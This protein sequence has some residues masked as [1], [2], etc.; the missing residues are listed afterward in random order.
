QILK[1]SLESW[2]KTNKSFASTEGGGFDISVVADTFKQFQLGASRYGDDLDNIKSYALGDK[3]IKSND[4]VLFVTAR[5]NQPLFNFCVPISA[6]NAVDKII[7]ALTTRA[8]QQSVLALSNATD[9]PLNNAIEVKVLRAETEEDTK[10]VKK[11]EVKE[12]DQH[13]R[14]V[15]KSGER[16]MFEFTNK[17]ESPLFMNILVIGTSGAISPLLSTAG[18]EAVRPGMSIKTHL[19]RANGPSGIDTFKLVIT[20][21]KTSFDFLRQGSMLRDPPYGLPRLLFDSLRRE[22]SLQLVQAPGPE[23]WGVYTFETE[24]Q[25]ASPEQSKKK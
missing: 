21:E 2:L 19:L 3:K 6:T 11:T 15:F 24:L 23:D 22:R 1:T 17:S 9:S 13:G 10:T 16:F 5:D 12:E 7:E 20:K 14:A 18:Q 8:R 25:Q 4:I